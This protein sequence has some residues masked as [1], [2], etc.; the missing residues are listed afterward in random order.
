MAKYSDAIK[1]QVIQDYVNNHLGYRALS[2]KHQVNFDSVRKWVALYQQHGS[3]GFR[4]RFTK[5]TYSLEFKRHVISYQH[6]NCWS[7]R[8]TAAHF[9]IPSASTVSVWEK[10]YN[11]VNIAETSLYREP[12][13]IMADNPNTSV[14]K[15]VEDMTPQEL[16]EEVRYLRAE[17]AYLKKLD[18]LI[19][20]KKLAEK[21]K[22]K[23][24]QN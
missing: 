21:N 22:P 9:N 15:A 12:S 16:M 6:S 8:Q 18:A 17:A 2:L 5:A 13:P 3:E 1:H 10:S 14:C 24:S 19:Q 20:Q 7:A 23:S 11:E 4:R